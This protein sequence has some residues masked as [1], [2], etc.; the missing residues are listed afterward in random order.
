M[1]TLCNLSRHV[2]LL[3]HS[4]SSLH[5][6]YYDWKCLPALTQPTPS[7]CKA[8]AIRVQTLPQLRE[9]LL[10]S[11]PYYSSRYCTA[12]HWDTLRHSSKLAHSL[13]IV[14]TQ[15]LHLRLQLCHQD[16]S[17]LDVP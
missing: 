9:Y 17:H 15:N 5:H 11:C 14:S 16:S 2:S 6:G 7:Q 10:V 12:L 8:E 4:K 1:Q 13:A 3:L